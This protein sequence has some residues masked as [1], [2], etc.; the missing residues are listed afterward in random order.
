MVCDPC[1]IGSEWIDNQE[2]PGHQ[3]LKLTAKGLKRFPGLKDR[4][5]QWPKHFLSYEHAI[6]DLGMN[7]NAARAAGILEEVKRPDPSRQFSYAGACE[8]TLSNAFG[9]LNF[10][11]GHAGAG[12]VFGSGYG[13]GCYEVWGRKNEDGRIVEV[14]IKMG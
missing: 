11:M 8:A 14:K 4:C 2:T 10:K 9:Q 7:A 3:P 6:S 5:W 13:D 1:Y 12:V